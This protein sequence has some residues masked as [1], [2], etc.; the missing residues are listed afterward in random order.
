MPKRFS[1]PCIEPGCPTLTTATRCP[2]HTRTY[3]R[4]THDP[5]R[6]QVYNSPR[7]RA[8]RRQ[9]LQ[10]NPYCC[11]PD[12]PNPATDLDHITPLQ[13]GTQGPPPDPYDPT[14]L[15]PLCRKHHS[16]KTQREVF[17]RK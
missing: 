3:D 4:A 15:Q 14:N 5:A 17:G 7:W 9:V 10:T 6:K 1:H 12:C 13:G 11:I 16:Q 8:L 2:D